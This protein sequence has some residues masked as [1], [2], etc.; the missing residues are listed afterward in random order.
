VKRLLCILFALVAFSGISRLD[1]GRVSEC[2]H[3]QG[4][5]VDESV[6]SGYVEELICSREYNGDMLLRTP[7]TIVT[8]GQNNL[9][10]INSNVRTRSESH[11]K[12]LLQAI[13]ERHA[14]HLTRFFEFNHFR[15]SLRVV[16][17]LYVLCRLRI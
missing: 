17:Y 1:D 15:S 7:R 14:G 9:T 13:P 16:Y 6:A 8:V 4:Y 2:G 10:S 5:V 3:T 11:V 12:S